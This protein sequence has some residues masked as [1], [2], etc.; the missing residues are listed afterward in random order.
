ML[1]GCREAR[2]FPCAARRLSAFRKAPHIHCLHNTPTGAVL[3]IPGK[4]ANL[5]QPDNAQHL[6]GQFHSAVKR[7]I[8]QPLLEPADVFLLSAFCGDRREIRFMQSMFQRFLPPSSAASEAGCSS[9]IRE[10]GMGSAS[11][12][13]RV[14]S[15]LLPT[16]IGGFFPRCSRFLPESAGRSGARPGR[17]PPRIRGTPIR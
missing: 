7:H 6:H 8:G 9:R 3:S 5:R 11:V 16:G 17:Y 15:F 10:A 4:P 2:F 14:I 1:G 12:Y 13:L